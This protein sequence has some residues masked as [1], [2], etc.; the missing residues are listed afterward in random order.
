MTTA[1]PGRLLL[2]RID[3]RSRPEFGDRG[4]NTLVTLVHER[5]EPVP[6]RPEPG[7]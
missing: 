4:C 1:D 6:G 7:D 3:A 2:D 5:A